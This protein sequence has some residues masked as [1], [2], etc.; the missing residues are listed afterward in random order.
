MGQWDIFSVADVNSENPTAS[1]TRSGTVLV[2]LRPQGAAT[3]TS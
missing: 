2:M 1:I 3:T